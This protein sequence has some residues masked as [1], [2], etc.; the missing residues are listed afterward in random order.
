MKKR[1]E[2]KQKLQKTHKHTKLLWKRKDQNTSP[3]SSTELIMALAHL[4]CLNDTVKFVVWPGILS[5]GCEATLWRWP[6]RQTAPAA[7]GTEHPPQVGWRT[8]PGLWYGAHAPGAADQNRTYRW[9][10]L[11]YSYKT[12]VHHLVCHA[13]LMHHG[14]QIRTAHRGQQNHSTSQQLAPKNPPHIAK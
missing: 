13:E 2:K 8:S 4:K 7:A 11:L 12:T 6:P 14:M 3:S 9:T 5:A 10:Y 1:E